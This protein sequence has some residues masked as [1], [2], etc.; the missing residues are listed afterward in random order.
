M[1]HTLHREGSVEALSKD[2]IVFAIASKGVN[3]EGS[4]EKLQKIF[5]IFQRH[6]PLNTGTAKAGSMFSLG[7]TAAVY[8]AIVDNE[9]VHGVFD[10][11]AT[12]VEVLRELKQEDLGLS[13]V[14]SGLSDHVCKCAREAGLEPHSSAQS[15][16][17]WGKTDLLP[18]PKVLEIATM[19]GHGLTSFTLIRELAKSVKDGSMTAEEAARRL[20]EPCV[21]GVFNPQ[22]AAVLI[23]EIAA[24]L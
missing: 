22:R 1:T 8:D 6:H 16:G 19:C 20:A 24:D 12:L 17:I 18:E 3:T 4:K 11:Q 23:Q 7:S 14:V 21:C 13:I 15:L 9:V 2:Y 10:S 5:N